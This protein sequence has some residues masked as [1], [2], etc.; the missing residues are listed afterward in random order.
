[1]M[2]KYDKCNVSE[3][4]D[5]IA[6]KAF[7]N[8]F[9]SKGK[10]CIDDDSFP[11]NISHHYLLRDFD[12]VYDHA[13]LLLKNIG[14]Y[15]E[16]QGVEEYYVLFKAITKKY[17]VEEDYQRILYESQED[18]SWFMDKWLCFA[19][20]IIGA[21][22]SYP[23]C[24]KLELLK[25]ENFVEYF[26]RYPKLYTPTILK[27]M[28]DVMF[29]KFFENE[30]IRNYY[31]EN[32]MELLTLSNYF[33]S[34]IESSYFLDARFIKNFS[35]TIDVFDFYRCLRI[36]SELGIVGEQPFIEEHKSFIDREVAGMN[37]GIL[38][39]LQE[40]YEKASE[41]IDCD[42]F[43]HYASMN[44]TAKRILSK[45]GFEK[46]PKKEFYQHFSKY[47]L[48]GLFMSRHF[49]TDPYNLMIDIE[50]LYYFARSHGHGLLGYFIYEFL[51]NFEQYS[52][53]DILKFYEEAKN[54]NL[55]DILYDDWMREKTRMIED[56]NASLCELSALP[57]KKDE[58]GI[59]Y[60]DINDFDDCILVTNTCVDI[61]SKENVEKFLKD[62]MT[63]NRG[64]EC[65]SFHN[66]HHQGIYRDEEPPDQTSV[67]FIMG[68]L[69]PRRVG[70]V[71]HRDAFSDGITK[72]EDYGIDYYKRRLYTAKELLKQTKTYSEIT[73]L[74]S[75]EPFLPIG[76]LVEEIITPEE[77]RIAKELGVPLYFR[78]HR[79]GNEKYYWQQRQNEQELARHYV[80]TFG[81]RRLF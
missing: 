38:P 30:R 10:D 26:L 7:D 71:Y 35:D 64:V 73:H 80:Y 32:P 45:A 15:G 68:P 41:Y 75:G 19:T 40:E 33:L 65:L 17:D 50:T 74:A 39:S 27:N 69:D 52:V 66:R 4:I 20:L 34:R 42:T 67:K 54:K 60:R 13:E 36:L 81:N 61:R 16:I 43:F 8:H 79:M 24:G 51:I 31:R 2:E 6:K 46:M 21:F 1:M 44:E 48:V 14:L 76:L 11:A 77:E 53:D 23:L 18:N 72:I 49:E 70:I 55:K 22:C 58:N 12:W 3:M 29:I 59:V 62:V 57:E 56:I 78:S 25:K 37:D 9:L 5:K 47:L 28:S 63:G